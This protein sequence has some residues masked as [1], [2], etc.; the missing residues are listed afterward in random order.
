M[1]MVW[2]WYGMDNEKMLRAGESRRLRE[3]VK[4]MYGHIEKRL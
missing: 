2:F 3:S 4:L 1:S